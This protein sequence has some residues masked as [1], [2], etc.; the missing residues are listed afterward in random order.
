MSVSTAIR[1]RQSK[2]RLKID[3]CSSLGC[4]VKPGYTMGYTTRTD[5]KSAAWPLDATIPTRSGRGVRKFKTCH[6]DQ[7]S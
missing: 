4:D 2:Q 6:S 3:F 5:A 7:F 1:A